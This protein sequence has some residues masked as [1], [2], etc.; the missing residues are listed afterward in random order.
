MTKK[1]HLYCLL[2]IIFIKYGSGMY[3]LP[4]S[5]TLL[6]IFR[7]KQVQIIE[8]NLPVRQTYG[9]WPTSLDYSHSNVSY[10]TVTYIH[11]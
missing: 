10:N 5:I 11:N 7:R 4:K 1:S 6:Y 3:V 2:V 9:A 8:Y